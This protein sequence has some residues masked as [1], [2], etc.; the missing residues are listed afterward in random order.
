MTQQSLTIGIATRGRA[1][2]A[3][4]VAEHTLRN[5]RADTRIVV[6]ADEDD[7]L[8]AMVLSREVILDI[9]PRP[10]TVA[11]KWNRMMA[12]APAQVYMAMC[13]YRTQNTPGF[14]RNILNAAA[15]YPDGIGAVY[16]HM[17]NLSFPTYQCVTARM[18]QIMGHIYVEHFPYWFVDHWLDDIC[19]MTGRFAYAAGE[20]TV[21]PR[22]GNG[23]TQ[24]FREP[25]MWATL[26]DAL[27]TEREAIANR[28]LTAMHVPEW[29]KDVLRAQWPLVHHRSRMINDLCRNMQGNAPH[30]ERYSKIRAKGISLLETLYYDMEKRAA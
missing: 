28:L 9:Q 6:L 26:Y 5:C 30:D 12:V 4:Q 17:A 29:Q 11:A 22:P 13:D 23:G 8:G 27:Y 24:D 15:L 3:A 1:E 10:D 21:Y 25:G 14:D 19:R 20:T 16:Q 2:L 7:D 18:A